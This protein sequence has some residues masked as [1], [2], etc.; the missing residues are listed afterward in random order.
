MKIISVI[1]AHLASVRFP[2]KVLH[3]IVG[4]PMIEHVRRRALLCQTLGSVFVA[5]CD[6]EIANVVTRNG[7]NVI[8]TSSSHRTGTD[9]V[10]EAVTSINCTHVMVLQADEPLL[11]PKD[12]DICARAI[13]SEPQVPCWNAVG[14][15]EK[16]EDFECRS[17]V[18][19]V[20]APSGRI[21][22]CSRKSLSACSTSAQQQFTRKILGLI[23]FRKEF[24][25]HLTQ[26]PETPFEKAEFIEQSR[27]LEN[28]F[29]LR[30]VAIKVSSPS[31]NEP[32]DVDV[33]QAMLKRDEVQIEIFKRIS[34]Q[35]QSLVC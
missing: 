24:L 25:L 18:K 12:I 35:I 17:V 1:P 9:R 2:R 28:G 15:I 7:G 20:I 29:E 26:L 22:F 11:L 8:M 4:L 23:A 34:K 13:I 10:A 30:G 31:V 32:R 27:V 14:P 19:C 3:P 33:I 6:Q 21:L 5:T 16:E